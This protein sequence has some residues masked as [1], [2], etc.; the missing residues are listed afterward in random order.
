LKSLETASNDQ[1]ELYFDTPAHQS[2][3]D[4]CS[5]E[6]FLRGGYKNGTST[7][8][9]SVNILVFNPQVDGEYSD[10]TF[11]YKFPNIIDNN[12][13]QAM[14][15]KGDFSFNTLKHGMKYLDSQ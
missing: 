3:A 7:S 10:D 1:I 15:A 9:L 13:Y 2:R 14:C 8:G 5:S 11:S 4:N 6:L 12:N